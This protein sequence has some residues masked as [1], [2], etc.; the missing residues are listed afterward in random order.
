MTQ[1][2]KE[3]IKNRINKAIKNN[4]V[5]KVNAEI[6]DVCVDISHRLVVDFYLSQNEPFSSGFQM[7][8]FPISC[9]EGLLDVTCTY[10]KDKENNNSSACLVGRYCRLLYRKTPEKD[11]HQLAD[12]YQF[13]GIQHIVHFKM[14]YNL[15]SDI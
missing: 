14:W 4:E 9:L 15:D 7:I 5:I 3:K 6:K 11:M 12:E 10:Q 8:A 2:Q 1:K 13:L